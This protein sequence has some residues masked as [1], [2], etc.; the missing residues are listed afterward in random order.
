VDRKEIEGDWLGWPQPQESENECKTVN[1]MENPIL[2]RQFAC[3]GFRVDDYLRFC[4]QYGPVC[5]PDHESFFKAGSFLEWAVFHSYLCD[6]LGLPMAKAPSFI[7]FMRRRYELLMTA[8]PPL[9][10]SYGRKFNTVTLPPLK[11]EDAPVR[12]ADPETNQR[13]AEQILRK[14]VDHSLRLL[15]V[16]ANGPF[17]VRL[18]V[19]TL[20]AALALQALQSGSPARYY[21]DVETRFC[22]RCGEPFQVG[23]GTGHRSTKIYCSERC[24]E[25]MKTE[26]KRAKQSV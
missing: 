9:Q 16:D 15:P 11:G 1:I 22:E 20:Q 4:H 3:L 12:P 24:Q 17:Q 14:I 8:V 18:T 19:K 26:R 10:I 6:F 25:A 23:P 13:R 2:Y 5:V 21:P 7:P